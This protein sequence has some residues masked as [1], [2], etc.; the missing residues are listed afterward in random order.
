[1]RVGMLPLVAAGCIEFG[2]DP[3]EP[4]GAP[5]QLVPVVDTFVQAPLPRVDLLF[6]VDDTASM[7][8]EQE[9]LAGEFGALATD[10]DAAEVAWQVGAVTTS[11]DGDEAGWLQG[12]PWILTPDTTDRAAAFAEMIRVGTKGSSPEAGLAAAVEAL[13]LSRTGGP[14]AGF[15]RPDALLH[16]VFVS[17]ADDQSEDYLGVDPVGAFLA[18]LADEEART[19]LPARASGLVG[20]VPSGCSSA[21]GSAQPPFRYADAVAA[22]GG[23]NVSICAP[24]FGPFLGSLGE[25][26]LAWRATFELTHAPEPGTLRVELDD[27][28]AGDFTLD[29]AT[30]EFDAPPPP[31]AVITARYL[32]RNS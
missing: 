15:R 9:A 12:S 4:E 22:T 8:Q 17:D 2:L 11:L 29:G 3:I 28:P 30:I 1:M 31:E 23:V 26:S 19:G 6:V 32:V 7:A 10:L 5:R 20:D 18:A 14:N 13:A 21:T 16:V 24:D 27:L 25:A